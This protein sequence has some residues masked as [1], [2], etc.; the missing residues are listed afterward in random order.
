MSALSS[1][2]SR[3][4]EAHDDLERA[5]IKNPRRY[6]RASAAALVMCLL[7]VGA[8]Y[9]VMSRTSAGPTWLVSISLGLLLYASFAGAR[10]TTRAM[11][12]YHAGYV[13]A[14][15]TMIGSYTEAGSRGMTEEEWLHLES[16]RQLT[17]ISSVYG[18]PLT[19]VPKERKR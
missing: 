7:N 3:L 19:K 16:E 18:L 10:S 15:F 5:A 8:V 4:A 6:R 1:L 12:A 9:V 2:P 17:Y 13:E 11:E 14:R